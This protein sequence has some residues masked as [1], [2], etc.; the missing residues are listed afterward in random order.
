MIPY[1]EQYA[2]QQLLTGQQAEAYADHFIA[3]HLSEMPYGGVYAKVSSA[4]RANPKNAAPAAGVQTALQGTTLRG[5]LVE[6]YGFSTFGVIA[7]WASIASF[8]LAGVMALLVGFGLW[9]SRRVSE[10]A[11]ILAPRGAVTPRG[12]SRR[13][14]DLF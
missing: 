12:V 8:V 14:S 9:H 11:E 2:G 7:L 1:L 3:V 4:S 5:L 6:A 13:V 10:S